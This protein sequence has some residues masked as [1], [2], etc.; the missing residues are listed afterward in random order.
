M[1]DYNAVMDTL[2]SILVGFC[3]IGLPVIAFI[4]LLMYA[5]DVLAVILII[6]L[7]ICLVA[8]F[9]AAGRGVRSF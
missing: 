2:K 1:L 5:P 7:I 8:L 9:Y 6:I 4:L 3:I